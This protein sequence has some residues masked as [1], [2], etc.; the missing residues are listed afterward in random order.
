[1]KNDQN[2]GLMTS[3]QVRDFFQVT[4]MS[5]WRWENNTELGFPV[6]VKIMRRKYYPRDEIMAFAVK[7]RSSA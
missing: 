4:E 3:K 1:M 7:M 2:N 5:I 6:P